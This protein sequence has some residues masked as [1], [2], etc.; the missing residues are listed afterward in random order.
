MD[1]NPNINECIPYNCLSNP[2]VEVL[3]GERIETGYTPIDISLSLTQFLLSEFVPGAGFVLGLVDIIWGIFGP[4]QWDAFLVQIEQLINQRIEEFA[5]NQAISRLEGLS[6]LYQ[7]YAESF[8]EWEADPTNPALRE[9]MRIQFNDMNSALTTAIPLFA[10]QNY[11]VPLLSVYVQAANLHLSVLRD[12]SVFGQRWG[13]DA[14]TINSRYNDLTRLIGNYT[15][16][17]VRW[18]NTGL[19]RVWG[20]DSRDWIRYNQFRRELTLTVLDI[21][22]LFPNYDSRTYPIRTVS[23]LTREIYTNPV[24]ENFDGSFRGSAQGIEGS[25]RS[26]H[27][28]D[29]LNSI[30]IYTDAHRGEYYWSGH[31]IMASPVGFSGPE[32]TFPLYGTMGNAAPQQRIVAQLGQGVYRT[33]S[34]TLYRRPFNIGINNQQLSVLDGTEFAYGTSSNLPSAVYRKSG[35]V[36]SLDEIPP[37]N[38]NVPP[39]QGFSHRL[40]HVSMFRSGFSNSS[41]SIIRAPMF[42]WIHR[43]AEFNNIIPSSQ[44]TQIPLTKSTNLGSGTSVVKGP[45][46]T[47]GDILRRTSPGQISTL[48]VNITAPLSQRYRVRIRYASTTNLQFHTSIDGR[49]I[50]QGN[51]SA[52]MS[53]G[54]NLQSGSFRTVGFTTPFNFSN[55]SSVFTL[56]AHVFNSG[57]EVYIDRIEFVPAEVTFEAEYDLERAQKAVNELFTSSNQIG[58]KTDVTDYHIDQVSNLVECLSDEFC[59]DE[60]K[61]LSEKV[62]H[63]KRLSDERN[64]LQDPNFRGI[65]RQLDRGWRGS[66]DI[67]IQ[68]GDDVF[69]ENYVTLLGTFDECYPTYLYQKIDESKLKAYTRYQLRGYIE[70]SQDLEIYLIRYNAK[71]ETVNVPGTGSLWP[72]SAPSP[73]GKCAHHSHHFSLDID[74]GCTDLNEDL[75]VWVIFKIKTQDG[76]ARLGNLEFLEEKPLV[77][78]ALARVKRAEKKWRDKREKLEWE[79]NIVYKEA[80]ES[81]DALFVN[82]QYDRLQADTNIAMIHAA[83]KRVH[84]IREAYLPEL[85]V[86]PGVNAAIF[87]EL[88]GRIFTAFSL[89]DARNVIKNGDFNNGLSCWNVKGHVDVEEQ[90]NHRSVLVVPEWEAEVS[91]EVRV[92]PGRGYILRVTAY[93]EGYGE[94]CVTIHEIENNTD[95]LKFSNCVEEEVYPNNTVTCNDYTATQEEYEGTYTSRNR[96]YDGAYESNSSVPA[97]Y[98]SAYE[99]K[100][101][102]D[103][104]RDNPCESNRGYGDYTPLPAGYVTK[105]LEYFPETDKVWIEIGETEG[106]FIVDSV[107]LLLMEE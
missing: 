5:R 6:N 16:H 85:S 21:V 105:E 101:Y 81:V 61:E 100:A 9:E 25:I 107:E 17:A 23:Q 75:G 33:L 65:N 77:G 71:H 24:L 96:G 32:F 99:E 31:Q 84:S 3:G 49:P 80:K 60:K 82:S 15:D 74:V 11:Q 64:L 42:S 48:R 97:D 1:N 72:L 35:T 62:K 91:Q 51:F 90:N 14:A 57:N 76:H 93:K 43:S 12:V 86:I 41:V 26:P 20:P 39:R 83:D 94:G 78:E 68:G 66:T 7:I 67:T 54:S 37:Q 19:E 28:M 10:V 4:S 29:I 44:I 58:L 69:K 92:C 70:D 106:T 56:S 55:G 38:N 104:R 40:S 45:G 52:T 95:E 63:A 47:G 13:F 46:F 59:L 30:T 103:G 50:N 98:A 36:D 2:E 73:I 8:R 79:T 88:E 34:S 18:Y 89:Y 102:T 27:L 53:S 87:E 22:S